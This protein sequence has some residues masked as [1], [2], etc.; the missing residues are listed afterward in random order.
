MDPGEAQV[1]VLL[2]ADVF[3][4][5]NPADAEVAYALVA[6]G[7]FGSRSFLFLLGDELVRLKG[8]N[9]AGC[10]FNFEVA[11]GCRILRAN[12]GLIAARDAMGIRKHLCGF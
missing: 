1:L 10:H 8:S 12:S 5:E 3:E 6:A 9:E 11:N 4:V 2:Q 7:S